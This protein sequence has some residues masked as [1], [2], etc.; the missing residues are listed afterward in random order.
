MVH[1]AFSYSYPAVL[2][3]DAAGRVLVLFPAFPEAAT[4]GVDEAEACAEA[5]DCLSEALAGRIANG[6]E[7]PP[8]SLPLPGQHLVSPDPTIALKAALHMAMYRRTITVGDLAELLE[9]DW[10]QAARLV[11]PKRSS[12]LTSLATALRALGCEIAISV[13][14]DARIDGGAEIEQQ[15]SSEK[16]G[17]LQSGGDRPASDPASSSLRPRKRRDATSAG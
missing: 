2:E 11:D 8:G 3:K 12:K 10:H 4:D 9:I 14:E 5:A 15:A 13:A 1:V 17:R 7:I 6:E 16:S